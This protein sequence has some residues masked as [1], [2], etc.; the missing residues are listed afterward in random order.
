MVDAN[1]SVALALQDILASINSLKDQH[2]RL[3]SAVDAITGKVNVLAGVKEIQETSK[4]LPTSNASSNGTKNGHSIPEG[5][6]SKS[7]GSP[8]L[9][10][11]RT[12]L[13]S[14]KIILTSYPGQSGVDPIPMNWGNPDP[15]IRG[16]V[17]VSRQVNTIRRRN[18]K[19]H[20]CV[21]W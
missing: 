6:S 15:N 19:I 20:E 11:R 9:T 8:E 13:A 14:S 18:G 10:G 16:P 2:A 7:P 4:S 5:P 17:V 12:S 3:A 1:D 21:L